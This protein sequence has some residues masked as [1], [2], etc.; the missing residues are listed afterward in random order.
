[1]TVTSFTLV[2]DAYTISESDGSLVVAIE[3]VSG[4]PLSQDIEIELQA[5]GGSA[6]GKL[7]TL[8]PPVTIFLFR[9][10]MRTYMENL[11]LG[12]NTLY[13]LF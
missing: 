11:I 4:G 9:K 8:Y 12:I 10:P 3:L 7:L 13:M 2:E 1:M 6:T 5:V